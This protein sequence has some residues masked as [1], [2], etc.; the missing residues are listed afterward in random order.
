MVT[1]AHLIDVRQVWAQPQPGRGA[2]SD[3]LPSALE[4]NRFETSMGW[5]DGNNAPH[6]G[7]DKRRSE[8]RNRGNKSELHLACPFYKSDRGKYQDC[9]KLQLKRI[10]DVKQHLCRKHMQPPYCPSCGSEFDN[11]EQQMKHSRVQLC[12]IRDYPRPDGITHDQK[13]R[14]SARA[15]RNMELSDQWF[16]MWDMVFQG[17]PRPSTAYVEDP[18]REAITGMKELWGQ[19]GPEIVAETLRSHQRSPASITYDES[20][21]ASPNPSIMMDAMNKLLDRFFCIY[22]MEISDAHEGPEKPLEA[23]ENPWEISLAQP[24]VNGQILRAQTSAE[25]HTSISLPATSA[26]HFE[27]KWH[28]G[29]IGGFAMG[30]RNVGQEVDVGKSGYWE[31]LFDS[32]DIEGWTD[33]TIDTSF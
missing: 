20:N 12:Q 23:L 7:Q 1:G 28:A 22:S 10:E 15:D 31:D 32:S 26:A 3:T 33:E 11:Q 13:E 14:L 29:S 4:Q 21:M 5:R 2:T 17:K 8:G 16:A 24:L 9:L 6:I 25:S 30:Q 19:K 27:P 18:M